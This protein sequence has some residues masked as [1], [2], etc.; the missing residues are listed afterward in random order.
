MGNILN[1]IER[2]RALIEAAKEKAA[3][4]SLTKK[5]KVIEYIPASNAENKLRIIFDN[6]SSM[7]T[8]IGSK[9]AVEHAKDGVVEF[10]R[11]CALNKDAVA[12]HLL[13]S[14]YMNYSQE[15]V[16]LIH[17]SKLTTNLIA[18]AT[19]VSSNRIQAAGETP[20]YDRILEAQSAEPRATRYIAFSDGKPNSLINEEK[21][22]SNAVEAK[23]PID[24]VYFGSFDDTAEV[25][26]RLADK[27]GGIF[28]KFDPSKGVDFKTA[29]K[30]LA[31][32]KRL[33][34]MNEEFKAK[35]ERGEVKI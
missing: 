18:L 19:E 17:V 26:Q 13:N 12:I 3:S 6:S 4:L 33:M 2:K 32:G 7:S 8:R 11:N 29:F 28:L 23:T 10:L 30:Y 25:M 1:P 9:Q 24:T 27:T 21:V 20:L 22:I 5:E 16:S 14:S 35:L 15:N 31:P 34:L